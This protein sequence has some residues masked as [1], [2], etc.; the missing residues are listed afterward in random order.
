[1]RIYRLEEKELLCFDW[2][3]IPSHMYVLREGEQALLI[4]AVCTDEV[5]R[6]IAQSGVTRLTVVLTHEH[7]DHISGV[8]H[9]RE[10]CDTEVICSRACAERICSASKNMSD[11]AE[12]LR[13]FN[14]DIGSNGGMV[15]PFVCHADKV[16]EGEYG[17]VFA[18]M[19]IRVFETAGHSTGSACALLDERWLFSGDTLLEYPT[20]VRLP[21]GSR[22]AF[23][24]TLAR[25]SKMISVEMV[26]P[27]HGQAMPLCELCR[28][29]KV[30]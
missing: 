28:I 27:G 11:K 26:Y 6:W 9:L 25:L 12:V 17:F 21:S 20:I 29:N 8:N 13:M 18:G 23:R 4:D 3:Y 24:D 10:L 14:S 19:R 30:K 7:F 15:E 5:K 16:F 22:A 2:D 1:M